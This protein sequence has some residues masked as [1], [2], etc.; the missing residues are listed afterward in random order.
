MLLGLGDAWQ[1][2]SVDLS[3]ESKDFLVHLVHRTG[4][5]TCPKCGVPCKRA[6]FD[7]A[8]QNR[9]VGCPT[10]CF[11]GYGVEKKQHPEIAAIQTTNEIVGRKKISTPKNLQA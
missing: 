2:E 6:D 8:C 5:F 4:H 1:V 11:S 7:P 3:I 10:M 9:R